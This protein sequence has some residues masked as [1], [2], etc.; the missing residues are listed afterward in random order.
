MTESI[1]ERL[2]IFADKFFDVSD[3]EGLMEQGFDFN[4]Y[5]EAIKNIVTIFKIGGQVDI[6]RF[7]E[8]LR[9]GCFKFNEHPGVV[10]E[11][12]HYI[13]R[14]NFH[15]ILHNV[16]AGVNGFDFSEPDTEPL[17]YLETYLY[18]HSLDFVLKVAKNAKQ[19]KGYEV[20]KLDCSSGKNKFECFDVCL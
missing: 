6:Q 14:D 12:C 1:K 20:K 10:T 19:G 2:E 9:E 7:A 13:H 17:K 11:F 15:R 8:Y 16:S 18:G 5:P 3:L 4:P